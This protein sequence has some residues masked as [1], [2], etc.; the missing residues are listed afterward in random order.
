AQRVD[1]RPH[2]PWQ[3][4]AGVEDGVP[5]ALG[6]SREVLVPVAAQLAG[7]APGSWPVA[8][9]EERDVVA[10]R[11]GGLDHVLAHEPGA[12]DDEKPHSRPPR[13]ASPPAMRT[14]AQRVLPPR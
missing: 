5:R 6:E 11:H 8:A 4:G 9:V 14:V 1:E 10:A 2:L 12:A 13:A 7:D 3:V